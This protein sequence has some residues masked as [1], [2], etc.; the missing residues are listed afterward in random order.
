L[1]GTI[2]Q[3]NDKVLL[4]FRKQIVFDRIVPSFHFINF[5]AFSFLHSI[6]FSSVSL[7]SLSQEQARSR[8]ARGRSSDSSPAMPR[9]G[10][11]AGTLSSHHTNYG[12]FLCVLSILDQSSTIL[13]LRR[14]GA[15]GGQEA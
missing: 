2:A 14:L 11:A 10:G 5:S 7:R 4:S 13:H 12:L 3:D 8:P 1:L 9:D 6:S 15:S